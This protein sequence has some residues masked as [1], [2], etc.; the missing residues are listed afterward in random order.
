MKQFN[1]KEC[2]ECGSESL[3]WDYTLR[4]NGGVQDGRLKYN[5]LQVVCYLGCDDCSE[6]LAF[7]SIYEVLDLVTQLGQQK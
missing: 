4:N 5:E 3:T 2:R 6:T 1:I 7:A